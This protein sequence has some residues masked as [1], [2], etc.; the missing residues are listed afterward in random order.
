MMF[1][2]SLV[3]LCEPAFVDYFQS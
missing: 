3:N 1:S 2:I